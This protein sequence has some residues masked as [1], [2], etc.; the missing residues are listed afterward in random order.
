MRTEVTW[1]R[2]LP[3]IAPA[4]LLVEPLGD[5]PLAVAPPDVAP[6]DVA[7]E[8]LGVALE[9]LPAVLPEPDIDDEANVPVTSIRCPLCADKSC[10]PG[11]ST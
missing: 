11:S 6:P 10:E 5:D 3:P 4:V 1:S 9:P 8:V 7:P 2:W